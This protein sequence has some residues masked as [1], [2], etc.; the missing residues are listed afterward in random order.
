[1]SSQPSHSKIG[2]GR[3]PLGADL[4]I[5][6]LA[7]V[8]TVY[9]LIST[10]NLSWEARV[11]G[12]MIGYTLLVLIALYLLRIVRR[13]IS[14]QAD[15]RLGDIVS[16]TEENG[17]RLAILGVFTAYVLTIEWLGATLGLFLTLFASMWILGVHSWRT[18]FGVSGL[19]AGLVYFLFIGFLKTR[20][21]RGPVEDLLALV[22]S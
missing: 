6:V 7:A 22:F 13:L 14:K 9:F 4:I 3:K 2:A 1:M 11:N 17:Q 20:L 12:M 18:L 19:T 15:L 21:P 8:F 16:I 10:S 5:P